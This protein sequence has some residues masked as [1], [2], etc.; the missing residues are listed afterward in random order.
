MPL[1][2]T[3]DEPR[4]M[5]LNKS[6]LPLHNSR[7]WRVLL[8]LALVLGLAGLRS[9][10]AADVRA[11]LSDTE[12]YVGSPLVLRIV[13]QDAQDYEAPELPEM[14]D[15]TIRSAG[16][17]SQSRRVMVING[18]RSED[19]QVTLNYLVTPHREGT[20]RIPPLEVEVAGRTV[21]TQ[22]LEFTASESD[23]LFVE[24]QG[25]KDRVYVGQPLDLTL[26]IWLKPYR[27]D[28]H[29]VVLS[30]ADMWQRISRQSSWGGF[31]D[32][33]REMAQRNAR[34]GGRMV[35]R[36]NAQGQSEEYYLY[37]IDG[38][39]YP[40]HPGQIDVDDVEIVVQYPTQ[41]RRSRSPFSDIFDDPF[42][43][44]SS[45]GTPFGDRLAI[46]ETRLLVGKATVDATRVLPVPSEGRPEHYRGAVGR[47]QIAVKASPKDVAAGEPITLDIGISGTGPMDRIQAPPLGQLRDLTADFKVADESL[48][49]FVQ[50][51][52]KLFSTT[53]RPRRA[54]ITRIPPI[55]FSYFDPDDEQ[56]HTV[57]SSPIS[58]IVS[59]AESLALDAI[60]GTPAAPSGESQADEATAPAT[61]WAGIHDPALLLRS[62]SPYRLST[63]W[64][65]LAI[66][67]PLAWLVVWTLSRR[68]HVGRWLPRLRSEKQRCVANLRRADR[69]SEL[70]AALRQSIA[71]R[72]RT[73]CPDDAHAVGALRAA[74]LYPVAAEVESFLQR[75]QRRQPASAFRIAEDR[76]SD[77]SPPAPAIQDDDVRRAAELAETLDQAFAQ[78]R[79]FRR[80]LA[81]GR[82]AAQSSIWRP[83]RRSLGVVLIAVAGLTS[84]TGQ[85]A[86]TKA[87]APA[88]QLQKTQQQTILDEATAAYQRGQQTREASPAEAQQAFETAARKYQL[89]VDSGL[90]NA[91]L[92]GNLGNAYLQSGQ[93]GRAIAS[94]HRA[95][96]FAPDDRSLLER[97]RHAESRV[98]AG[99]DTSGQADS[100][101]W[102]WNSLAA[103]SR[104]F[105]RT[106]LSWIGIGTMVTV[107]ATASFLFWGLMIWRALN[108]QVPIWP[109]AFA[110]AIVLAASLLSLS[111]LASD[112]ERSA[113]GVF[114]VDAATLHS[115]D[116]ESFQAVQ[117]V[118]RA[119]G[120]P[121]RILG[122]RGDWQHVR[123]PGGTEGW[124]PAANI[125]HW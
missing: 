7:P 71:T 110:P 59:E 84:G 45:R 102:S 63:L 89:L 44:G 13:I 36:T 11:S 57:H 43:S 88:A 47:Y 41:L 72:T 12:A 17:P 78:R 108:S 73:A 97:L 39:I 35:R 37:E 9:A 27:D 53:I 81:E 4:T 77:A 94:Y 83:W 117:T 16:P 99:P 101:A 120:R 80:G 31:S 98:N 61:P 67:P 122:Q 62:D 15:C 22:A 76:S 30:E 121:L 29:R 74:G 50:D 124:V 28:E 26:Q 19:I 111:L 3:E 42:F 52:T 65:W 87:V 109:W 1:D 90:Q 95:L 25:R 118:P 64:W 119:D 2:A 68:E 125:E 46:A 106:V 107:L 18:R 14:E 51:E 96:R 66:L 92:Y 104:T 24:I 38:T 48:A 93:L 116:G 6:K 23:L 115:G 105:N 55:P 91:P 21:S 123:L 75:L 32:R 56:F 49:G 79:R 60:V 5:W 20:F 40:T 10:P 114:V 103:T 86:Q 34:P 82:S 112:L 8:P 100:G 33:L 113:R 58:I 85:A 54:G 69:P 70:A